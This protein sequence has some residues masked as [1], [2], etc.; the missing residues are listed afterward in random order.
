MKLPDFKAIIYASDYEN[1]HKL[2]NFTA[3]TQNDSHP[4]SY[5]ENVIDM[6]EVKALPPNTALLVDKDKKIVALIQDEKLVE[7]PLDSAINYLALYPSVVK[8]NP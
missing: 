5:P 4:T 1:L 8:K 2:M 7:S 3:Y 6:I